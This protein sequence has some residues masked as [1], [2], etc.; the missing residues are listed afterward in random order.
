M[1][2][3][4]VRP[5]GWAGERGVVDQ[6]RGNVSGRT[7]GHA[8]SSQHGGAEFGWILLPSVSRKNGSARGANPLPRVVGDGVGV[9]P[10]EV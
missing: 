2:A 1:R 7:R 6:T 5:G 8:A 10:R 9:G 4:D 3:R